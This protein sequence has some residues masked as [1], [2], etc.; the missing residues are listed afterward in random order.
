MEYYSTKIETAKQD[1]GI[2]AQYLK[3][4]VDKLRD[5]LVGKLD[6]IKAKIHA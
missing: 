1:I 4:E 5:E 6:T 3:K 2:R